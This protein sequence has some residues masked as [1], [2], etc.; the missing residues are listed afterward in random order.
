MPIEEY[1]KGAGHEY[2]ITDPDTGQKYYGRG[3]VQTTWKANYKTF[4]PLVKQDLVNHPELALIPATAYQIMSIGMRRGMFTG[5]SLGHYFNENVD[6]AVN[7][8]KIIN[9]LDQA[10][11]IAGFHADILKALGDS[12]VIE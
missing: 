8:R 5:V 9:G 11:R 2:G 10:E 7:A 1:G 12:L 3:Y 6:D 4:S